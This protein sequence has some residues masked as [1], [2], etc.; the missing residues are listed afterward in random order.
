MQ[1]EKAG[2]GCPVFFAL[3]LKTKGKMGLISLNFENIGIIIKNE[4]F[5]PSVAAIA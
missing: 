4:A 1:I 5:C 3:V 2:H